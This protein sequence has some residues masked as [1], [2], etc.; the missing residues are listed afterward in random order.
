VSCE[1]GCQ[2]QTF[3]ARGPLTATRARTADE[4]AFQSLKDVPNRPESS[5]CLSGAG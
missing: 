4:G 2:Q 3:E 5:E 1:L